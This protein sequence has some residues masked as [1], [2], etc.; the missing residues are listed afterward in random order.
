MPLKRYKSE[1]YKFEN[2]VFIHL[3][4]SKIPLG[5]AEVYRLDNCRVDGLSE[6]DGAQVILLEIKY[7]L[8]WQTACNARL[9]VDND[10]FEKTIE[11]LEQR[12]P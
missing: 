4:K 9:R 8:N 3:F 12:F 2:R 5:I 10:L 7:A 6:L 1:A 11:E